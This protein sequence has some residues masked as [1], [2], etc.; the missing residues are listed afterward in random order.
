MKKTDRRA[1]L[2]ALTS[3]PLVSTA[4]A[5]PRVALRLPQGAPMEDLLAIGATL[6]CDMPFAS[7]CAAALARH[8][9]TSAADQ[10]GRDASECV[11]RIAPYPAP[12][13]VEGYFECMSGPNKGRLVP[14]IDRIDPSKRSISFNLAAERYA[15]L[16]GFSTDEATNRLRADWAEWRKRRDEAKA[17]YLLDELDEAADAAWNQ[18]A[19][20]R[21]HVLQHPVRSLAALQVKLALLREDASRHGDDDAKYYTGLLADVAALAAAQ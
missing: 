21:D 16:H 17:A 10:L 1:L 6:C 13:I 7:A 5:S 8:V 4:A 3:V 14:S 12:L 18:F 20:A 19:D 15:R 2:V 11:E 9:Q